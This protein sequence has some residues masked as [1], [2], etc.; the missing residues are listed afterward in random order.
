VPAYKRRLQQRRAERRSGLDAP[1][2]SSFLKP[3]MG[4]GDFVVRAGYTRSYSRSGLN[5]FTGPLNNNPGVVITT[6]LTPAR[7][8]ATCSSVRRRSCSQPVRSSVPGV[9]RPPTYPILPL[10]SNG[11]RHAEHQRF[12]SNIQVPRA[13]SWQAGFTRSVGKSMAVEVRYVGTRGN[14]DWSKPEPERVQHVEKR[15]PHE[16]KARAQ[17][18]LQ[19][20][21]RTAAA[22][23]FAFTGAPGTAPL[24]VFLAFFNGPTPP[25]PATPRPTPAAT[26]Q[27]RRS[28]A[29][30]PPR[31]TRSRTTSPAAAPVR[32]RRPARQ[33]PPARQRDRG[34]ACPQLLSSPI[35]KT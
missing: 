24:P 32:P 1:G 20:T 25:T 35:R 13:D 2:A 11:L 33:R 6:P 12:A 8:T 26:G 7:A 5:D 21:L 16:F 34:R 23:T 28:S 9:Q 14:G 10:V 15:L 19:A 27:T 30:S 18:N 17:K 29:T 22:N 3:L 4:E 31:R